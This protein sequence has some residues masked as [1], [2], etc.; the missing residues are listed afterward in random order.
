MS[1]SNLEDHI[2]Y[3]L[4]CLSNYVSGSFAKRLEAK[5]ISVP[6]WVV[7]RTLY[8]TDS[9]TLNSAAQT[10][11][12]DKSTL[13]RMVDR[14]L[15][16]GLV[17]RAEGPDRRSLSL[18]LTVKGKKLVPELAKLA[19]LNDAEFFSKFPAKQR[20]ELL[21]MIKQLLAANGWDISSRGQDGMN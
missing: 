9:M 1:V 6:Q 14:L 15:E 10:I 5:D 17:K 21:G 4:R 7:L 20:H 18:S 12:V 16:K 19:D 2:G 13:S 3:W 11:G 8:D